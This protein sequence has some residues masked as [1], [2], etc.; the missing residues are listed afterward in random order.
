MPDPGDELISRVV[1]GADRTWFYWSGRESVRDLERTIGIAGR[2][3]DSFEGILDF[4]CGCGRMLLWMEELGRNRKLHGTDIDADAIDWCRHHVPHAEVTVNHADPPLP[5]PARSFDLVFSHSVFTHLDEQRQDAWLSELQRV[6][7]PGALLVLS[8][9]GEVDLGD[10]AWGIRERLEGQGIAFI[11]N[12]FGSWYPLPHW[13]QR[14]HH[15][16]WYVF[17]HWGRWFKISAYLPGAA[18]G[19]QDQILLERPADNAA[20]LR[21]LTARPRRLT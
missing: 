10:D 14:T 2:A 5:Y 15:A 7:R 18:V 11:D 21:P 6:T 3:L 1:G 12:V 4:G 16:P 17:E 8:T 20:P 19:G 13:Y 9:H